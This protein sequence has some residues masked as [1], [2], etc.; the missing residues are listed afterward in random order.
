MKSRV[1][2]T[3]LE[4]MRWDN[5]F[6]WRRIVGSAS[7]DLPPTIK[8]VLICLSFCG[9][10]KGRD[11]FPSQAHV[12]SR[13]SVCTR[14]VGKALRLGL[15]AGYLRRKSRGRG[16]LYILTLP[17]AMENAAVLNPGFS[18]GKPANRAD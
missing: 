12:A 17:R 3:Q 14:T 2:C 8:L 13:A 6:Q 10:K 4:A 16:Y 5:P 18:E 15:E 11:I 9:N 1:P 7:C